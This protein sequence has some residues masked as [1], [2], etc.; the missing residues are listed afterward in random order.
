MDKTMIPGL[1]D[2]HGHLS[3]EDGLLNIASGVTG[4][5]DIGKDHDNIMNV[6]DQY[7]SGKVIGTHVYRAGFIDKDSPFAA[8]SGKVVNTLEEAI[9]AVDWY[10]DRGYHH[11]KLYSSIE[12]AWVKPIAE[13]THRRGLRL[14]GHIPAFMTAA[15]AIEA[16]YDEIQHLNMVFLNFLGKNIDTRTR[17]TIPGLK[18]GELDINSKEVDDFIALLKR[19]KAAIDPTVV[20]IRYA[21]LAKAG[22][23]NETLLY[24]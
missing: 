23:M 6:T 22:Q 8:K 11:I 13:H 7:E 14:S 17:F 2:M 1:W 19:K 12:P 3:I 20:L 16:G 15:E 5:R 4:V 9:A 24:P 10:A 18:G 21:S